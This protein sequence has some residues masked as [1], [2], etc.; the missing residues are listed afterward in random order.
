VEP[1]LLPPEPPLFPPEE[2]LPVPELDFPLPPSLSPFVEIGFCEM[3][4]SG[5]VTTRIIG[6]DSCIPSAGFILK[7]NFTR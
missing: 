4:Q 1:P 6:M 2:E 7:V 5:I 3:S